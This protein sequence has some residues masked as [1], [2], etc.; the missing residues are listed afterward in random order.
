MS[1]QFV[2]FECDIRQQANF[3]NGQFTI[4]LIYDDHIYD[5]YLFY[6][7]EYKVINYDSNSHFA[8]L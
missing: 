6:V 7:H 8:D 5:I 4:A 1:T 2:T 3:Y